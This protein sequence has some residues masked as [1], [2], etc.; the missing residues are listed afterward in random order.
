MDNMN[1]ILKQASYYKLDTV[2]LVVH[3]EMK[4]HK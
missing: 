3:K 1:H 2:A 4:I